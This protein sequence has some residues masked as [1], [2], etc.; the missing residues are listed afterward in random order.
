MAG[1]GTVLTSLGRIVRGGVLGTWFMSGTNEDE[2]LLQR[3]L[4]Q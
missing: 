2:L 1:T 4:W 3:V